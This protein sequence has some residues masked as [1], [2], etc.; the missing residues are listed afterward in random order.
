MAFVAAHNAVLCLDKA[1]T[2][3]KTYKYLKSPDK[4]L[5]LAG[6][7]SPWHSYSVAKPLSALT[8]PKL[9]LQL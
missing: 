6:C 9:V 7:C 3:P 8:A 1:I 5:K 4:L 2:L